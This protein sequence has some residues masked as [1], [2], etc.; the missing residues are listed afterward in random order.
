MYEAIA[1]YGKRV[2]RGEK[3]MDNEEQTLLPNNN[4]DYN[5]DYVLDD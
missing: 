4:D 5:D 2:Q 1:D 3:P